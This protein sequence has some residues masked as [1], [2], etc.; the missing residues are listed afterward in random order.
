M[1]REFLSEEELSA[2]EARDIKIVRLNWI[3]DLFVFSCYTG[4]AYI[5]AMKLTP[6]NISIG[7]G[8]HIPA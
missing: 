8:K 3:R 2:I 7:I 4:L 1:E 6:S 5:D